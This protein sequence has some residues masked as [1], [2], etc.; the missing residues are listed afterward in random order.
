MPMRRAI[1]KERLPA[2][3]ITG[4]STGIGRA[5]A[6]AFMRAGFPTWASARRLEAIADLQAA[7]C[8]ILQLDVT[9]EDS[10]VHAV[11]TVESE[12][13]AV[14]ALINNAG[15]ALVGP[16]EEMSLDSI[17]QL[18]EVN[19][20]GLVRLCQLVLPRMRNQRHGT[21]VNLGSVAGLLTPPGGSV[22][23]MTKYGLEALSDAMRFELK[24]FGVRVVLME[25]GSV[26]TEL[27][28]AGMKTLPTNA[29]VYDT[30]KRNFAAMV[31]RAHREGAVGI[32]GP[33]DVAK[34]V[35]SAVRA[36]RP[37]S[38]YRVGLQAHLAPLI[39]RLAGDNVW[40]AMMAHQVPAS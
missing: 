31:A 35:V 18:F 6:L 28:T 32:L 17:R 38:R 37:R 5:T 13:G 30:F 24:P 26:R 9:N 15:Q 20:F 11:R 36:R 8:H 22:Y 23:S 21:I 2:A 27:M 39:R 19:L 3:L 40:D 33:H 34:V 10:C 7:G 4:C 16:F 12:H 14:G 1:S 25:I 29:S